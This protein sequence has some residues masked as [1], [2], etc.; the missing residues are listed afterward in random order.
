VIVIYGP[1]NSVICATP[2]TRIPAGS[3]D[4]DTETLTLIAR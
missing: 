2:T 3:Y 4:T 1:E